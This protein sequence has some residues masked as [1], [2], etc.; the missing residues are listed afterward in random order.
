MTLLEV[1]EQTGTVE[2]HNVYFDGL[3]FEVSTTY[4]IRTNAYG[5]CEGV[6]V[7]VIET[8]VVVEV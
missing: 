3:S 5:K 7:D 8:Y 4:I 1:R 6:F 2:Y